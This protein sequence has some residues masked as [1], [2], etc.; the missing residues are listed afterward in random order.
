LFCTIAKDKKG[1]YIRTMSILQDEIHP[2]HAIGCHKT[3]ELAKKKAQKEF[4]YFLNACHE[5]KKS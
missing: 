1:T 4:E 5:R 2:G 3:L